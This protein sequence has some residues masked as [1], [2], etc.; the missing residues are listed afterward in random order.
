MPDAPASPVAPAAPAAAAAPTST[1]EVAELVRAARAA[2]SPVRI[3]GG[4]S[5]LDAGR[6]VA[7][8]RPLPVG[9]LRGIV[10]YVPGDLTITA[11]AGTPLAD[12]HRATRAEGQW[13]PLDPLGGPASTLGATIA[14]ASAGPLSLSMGTPRDVVLGLDAVLGTGETI[15]A[16]GRVVKNVA[17]FDLVRLLTGAWGTL[18]VITQL[19]IRLRARPEVDTTIAVAAPDETAALEAWLGRILALPIAPAACEL[20][21]ARMAGRIGLEARPLLLVRLTGN[22]PLVDGQRRALATSAAT[23]EFSSGAELWRALATAEPPGAACMRWSARPTRFA[24]LWIAAMRGAAELGGAATHGTPGRG[25]VRQHVP[26]SASSAAVRDSWAG[27]AA[28]IGADSSGGT[29]RATAI[30]ERLPTELWAA[31]ARP[32]AADRI[33]RGVRA[34]FDPDHLLNPGVLG[35]PFSVPSAVQSSHV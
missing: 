21:D 27:V 35:E 1:F 14:T 20:I 29:C 5:W 10:E 18:G 24:E 2:R 32:A 19:S 23:E 26:S 34:A 3:I 17:G 33:S 9:A 7:A 11:L 6:P 13:L 12:L 16:G 22:A 25:I 15:V 30:A 8:S 31:L 4:G 28:S